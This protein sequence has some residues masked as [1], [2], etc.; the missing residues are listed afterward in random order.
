[1]KQPPTSIETRLS[2]LSSNPEIFSE[3]SKH[4]QNVLN[5]S[6]YDGMT[7]TFKANHQLMK[8][9][10]KVNRLPMAKEIS[11]G[12]TCLFQRM[13]QTTSVNIS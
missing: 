13:S 10:T 9:K 8:I 7:I 1:M 5:L 6:E 3:A 12:S 4:S 11:L 2:N